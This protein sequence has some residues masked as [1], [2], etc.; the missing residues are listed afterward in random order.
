[1][2]VTANYMGSQR[3][4]R[5]QLLC[6]GKF[7]KTVTLE[8]QLSINTNQSSIHYKNKL[9]QNYAISNVHNRKRFQSLNEVLKT[10]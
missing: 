9:V 3:L 4:K 1:M 5:E 7:K 8:I 10:E 6:H 2:H